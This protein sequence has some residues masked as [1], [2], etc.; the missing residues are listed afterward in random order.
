MAGA[1]AYAAK[2]AISPTTTNYIQ[3]ARK[4]HSLLEMFGIAYVLLF[5]PTI[6]GFLNKKT[7]LLRIH[8]FQ[9][10]RS[11]PR[12]HHVNYS[13]S[14]LKAHYRQHL[15]P[16]GAKAGGTNLFSDNETGP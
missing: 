4:P 12:E 5:L 15:I 1:K 13:K 9:M 6:P 14:P 16:V 3:S 7:P 2:L 11:S 10:L 8:V